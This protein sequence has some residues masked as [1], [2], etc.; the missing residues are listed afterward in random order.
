V[1][2][3][4]CWRA[5]PVAGADLSAFD[6]RLSNFPPFLEEWTARGWKS[7]H[8]EPS[9]DPV[10][11]SCAQGDRPIDVAF[12]G[13]Y[14]RHHASR[15]ALLQVVAR[16]AE[17]HAV[18]FHLAIARSARLVNAVPLLA[19]LFPR[20]ALPPSFRQVIRPPVFGLAMYRLF[21]S[22]RVVLNASIDMAGRFRGNM[23]CWEALGC[24]A[25]MV[26]EEGDY[27]SGMQPNEHFLTY[28]SAD[29]AVERIAM[30]L[31]DYPRF[32][33]MGRAGR[34]SVERT[35]SKESQWRAFQALVAA[36]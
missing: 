15:N 6:L 28:A 35:Y 3:T 32:A 10:A 13:T 29:E 1:R 11:S 22:S 14:S 2:K 12:V 17:R 21:G 19:S 4:V 23:R 9:H 5:A 8:F 7:A 26:G 27:P 31:E 36:L 34:A 33:A 20:L 16:L 18:R 25:V 24:G 30:V